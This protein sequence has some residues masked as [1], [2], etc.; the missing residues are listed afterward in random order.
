MNG[1]SQH[2]TSH[3]GHGEIRLRAGRGHGLEE[4]LRL[5]DPS[6]ELANLAL[7]ETSRWRGVLSALLGMA[8][9]LNY[10]M[11]THDYPEVASAAAAG[12]SAAPSLPL[13][14][15]VPTA[16]PAG[17]P[18]GAVAPAAAATTPG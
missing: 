9:F 3:L 6:T 11:W 15:S 14:S 18:P 4:R 1:A 17:A 13:D 16:Q 5:R 8:L 7:E 12:G 2:R 10:Q